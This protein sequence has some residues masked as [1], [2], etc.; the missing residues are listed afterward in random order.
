MLGDDSIALHLSHNV[1]M[2][3]E[4]LLSL[5]R[6]IAKAMIVISF[7]AAAFVTLPVLAALGRCILMV[8]PVCKLSY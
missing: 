3:S 6:F 8:P 5:R 2:L 7:I 1:L 4:L